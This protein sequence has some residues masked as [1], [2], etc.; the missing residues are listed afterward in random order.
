MFAMAFALGRDV[1]PLLDIPTSRAGELRFL[2]GLGGVVF[3]S[4]WI[5]AGGF[6]AAFVRPIRFVFSPLL[7][8]LRRKHFA[9]LAAI[10]ALVTAAGATLIYY[11]H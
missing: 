1:E 2:A 5:I 10:G 3:G 8:G 9:V 6:C 4:W 7:D 11:R